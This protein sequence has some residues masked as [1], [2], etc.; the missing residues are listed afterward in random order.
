M[1]YIIA[2][3]KNRNSTLKYYDMLNRSRLPVSII[4]TPKVA[5]IGCGICVK[6]T[7]ESYT[8]AYKILSRARVNSFVAFYKIKKENNKI[9][10]IKI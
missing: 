1:S 2:V 4:S 7:K 9:K 8:F 3:F 10:A 6:M 5:G